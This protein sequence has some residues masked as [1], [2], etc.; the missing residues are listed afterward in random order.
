MK[1]T[2][3]IL[4]AVIVLLFF[5]ALYGYHSVGISEYKPLENVS[6]CIATDLHYLSPELTDGGPAFQALIQNSDGKS[7]EDCETI[8]DS[9]LSQVLAQQ[10]DIL[11]LSGDLTFNGE[12]VSHEALCDKLSQI[13][14]A[15]IPVLVIPGNHDLENSM[16]A[17]FHGDDYESVSSLNAAEFEELYKDFG[18]GD[19]LSRDTASLS[20]VAEIRP[21]LRVLM[22]DVNATAGTGVLAE[23]T[24]RWAV[25]QFKAARRD[26]AYLLAVSHQNLLQHNGLLSYGY[27]MENSQT[28]LTQYEAYGVLC[29]L[30]GHTHVQHIAQSQNGFTEIVTSS[31]LIAPYQYG[32]LTLSGT[33]AA[34]RTVELPLP[35]EPH[36]FLWETS[37]RQAADALHGQTDADAMST[38]FADANAAYFAGRPDLID[39]DCDP[40]ERWMR[41]YG[42]CSA[43]L[44]SIRNEGPKN[45]TEFQFCF[46]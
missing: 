39:W 11:I 8:I 36:S 24:L 43:Y 28:L 29:N 14:D 1:K 7:M 45:Q 3:L 25:K 40:A 32:M 9:F 20:Y 21:N 17:S 34:Y 16:A 18:L 41:Q 30:S 33:S 2:V 4:S 37:Y 35:D 10:P 38:F 13:E 12:R 27:V 15:G 23:D 19:A 44:Q 5:T 46:S 31:L 42:F 26:G 6:V 22:L